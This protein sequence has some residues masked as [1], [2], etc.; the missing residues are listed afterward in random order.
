MGGWLAGRELRLT[1]LN[2]KRV[3]LGEQ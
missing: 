1:E 3:Y 2:I